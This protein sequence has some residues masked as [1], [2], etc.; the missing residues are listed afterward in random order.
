M[1]KFYIV[2]QACAVLFLS[3]TVKAQSSFT[4]GILWSG[5]VETDT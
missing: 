2:L 3:L 5:P 1:R 4:E